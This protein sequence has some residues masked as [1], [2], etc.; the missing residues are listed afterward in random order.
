MFL[1]I[2]ALYKGVVSASA[3]YGEKRVKKRKESRKDV[4]ARKRSNNSHS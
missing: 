4:F 1:W 2:R 3:V